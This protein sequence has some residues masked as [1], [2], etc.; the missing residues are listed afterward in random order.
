MRIE[1]VNYTATG[2]PVL[3]GGAATVTANGW[4][5]TANEYIP[6]VMAIVAIASTIVS[7]L[8]Y[9]QNKKKDN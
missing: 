9:L 3:S 2:T 6:L 4:I 5:T 8:T 1:S 7:I